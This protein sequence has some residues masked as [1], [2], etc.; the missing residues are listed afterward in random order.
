PAATTGFGDWAT[1]EEGSGGATPALPSPPLSSPR[2]VRGKK[3]A[4]A[5]QR[6]R[7]GGRVRRHGDEEGDVVAEHPEVELHHHAPPIP[8]LQEKPQ[9][10]RLVARRIRLLRDHHQRR[11]HCR[12]LRRDHHCLRCGHHRRR[13]ERGHKVVEIDGRDA[14]GGEDAAGV[15]E[16]AK[17]GQLRR[18]RRAVKRRDRGGIGRQLPPGRTPPT[19]PSAREDAMADEVEEGIGRR[20]GLC[21]TPAKE[22]HQPRGLRTADPAPRH[23]PRCR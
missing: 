12:R 5:Q 1:P 2:S 21:G 17:P 8:P 20:P 4:D 9:I 19:P 3:A 18:G 10:Q 15:D 22:Q 7:R 16:A 13:R 6:R 14:G 23:H 11:H